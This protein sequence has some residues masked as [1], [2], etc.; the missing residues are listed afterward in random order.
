MATEKLTMKNLAEQIDV[1]AE[2]V[3][4]LVERHNNLDEAVSELEDGV[5]T[6]FDAL[7]ESI[8][9]TDEDLDTCCDSQGV[10]NEGTAE[11]LQWL[12]ARCNTL[13]AHQELL[14]DGI[15]D[16]R[17]TVQGC[18]KWRAIRSLFF[19]AQTAAVAWLL[20]RAYGGL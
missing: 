12:E 2:R 8:R 4:G 14:R 10:V 13:D 1:L 19:L 17:K 6:D 3:D 11:R 20:A 9:G 7:N 16:Q 5:I 15:I 18:L